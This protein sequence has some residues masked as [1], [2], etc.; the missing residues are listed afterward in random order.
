MTGLIPRGLSRTRVTL[1]VAWLTAGF[2]GRPTQ[3]DQLGDD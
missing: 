2:L 1:S 3:F